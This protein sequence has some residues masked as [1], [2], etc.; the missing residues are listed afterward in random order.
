MYK[1]DTAATAATTIVCCVVLRAPDVKPFKKK[2]PVPA[3]PSSSDLAASS[4]H[5]A[6]E[7][8]KYKQSELHY[9]SGKGSGI[10]VCSTDKLH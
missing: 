7:T 10:V 8:G 9:V 6:T 3:V 2:K 4:Q 1:C 5:P